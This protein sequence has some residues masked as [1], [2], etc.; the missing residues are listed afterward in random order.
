MQL[1]ARPAHRA[2]AVLIALGFAA[3]ELTGC[4]NVGGGNVELAADP[5]DP[6]NQYRVQFAQS[7]T[8]FT[9]QIVSGA[10]TGGAIG[11]AGGALIGGASG[12]GR[13]ALIGALAG[14]A[15][16]VLVGGSSAYYRNMQQHAR[17]QAELARG[18]NSDLNREITE[19]DHVNA[20]FARLRECRFRTAQQ[21]KY[22][23][24]TGQMPRPAAI[25]ALDAQRRLFDQEI[26]VARQYGATMQKRDEQF[27][28]AAD[29]LAKRD[30]NY[31]PPASYE[32]GAV[33]RTSRT[34][35]RVTSSTMTP[36]QQAVANA[37]QTIPE[38]RSSFTASVDD[39]AQKSQV[40]FNVDAPSPA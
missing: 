7:K 26:A 14:G 37:T 22:E 35:H 4:T 8:F 9:D 10:L 3:G 18:I 23:V 11:A 17:D 13:G 5:S 38:K 16:G 32:T 39:A 12:G 6:C 21:I 24:R 31:V 29:N 1:I 27:Q 2:A 20:T 30:P 28:V 25:E 19:L 33:T 15:A 34:T 40:A 36:T